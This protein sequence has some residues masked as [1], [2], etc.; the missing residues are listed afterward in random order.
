M[1]ITNNGQNWTAPI[2]GKTVEGTEG[3]VTNNEVLIT[4]KNSQ[5]IA[6][7]GYSN[8]KP[9]YLTHTWTTNTGAIAGESV[10]VTTIAPNIYSKAPQTTQSSGFT[11]GSCKQN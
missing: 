8:S 5:T 2:N 10:Q 9:V 11:S 6:S 7:L 1:T 3:I 4:L